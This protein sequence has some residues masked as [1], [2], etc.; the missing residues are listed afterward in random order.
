MEL[1]RVIARPLKLRALWAPQWS[2]PAA[3]H[4]PVPG[5]LRHQTVV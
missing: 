3:A 2:I 1:N 5:K 4:V